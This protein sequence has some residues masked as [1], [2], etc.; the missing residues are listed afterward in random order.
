MSLISEVRAVSRLWYQRPIHPRR[1]R[2]RWSR[3]KS[4][5]TAAARRHVAHETNPMS[6][7]L[8]RGHKGRLLSRI[9]LPL[10]E[11]EF[12]LELFV[13]RAKLLF[14][15]HQSVVIS[16]CRVTSTQQIQVRTERRLPNGANPTGAAVL[17]VRARL[18]V[19]NLR[20]H[21]ARG[22]PESQPNEHSQMLHS[23]SRDPFRVV[24]DTELSIDAAVLQTSAL[25]VVTVL[26]A[27]EDAVPQQHEPGDPF[28][29]CGEFRERRVERHQFVRLHI[30]PVAWQQL[31]VRL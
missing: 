25:E 7:R 17:T 13:R 27:P 5:E 1:Q 20:L 2:G 8:K 16:K 30:Q 22:Q 3:S 28:Q 15:A 18:D 11:I 19:W 29:W 14:G 10:D 4:L 9:K 12:R 21:V 23:L 6:G 26:N 31:I 24:S